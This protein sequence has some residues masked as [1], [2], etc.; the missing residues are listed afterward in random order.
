MPI[1]IACPHCRQSLTVP[2][3]AAGSFVACSVCR[4]SL[5]VPNAAAPVEM[6]DY[7]A[8]ISRESRDPPR[9]QPR[10]RQSVA[11]GPSVA[12]MTVAIV[13]GLLIV[14]GIIGGTF[15]G[16]KAYFYYSDQTQLDHHN[17]DWIEQIRTQGD[18]PVTKQY[19]QK[20]YDTLLKKDLILNR[21]TNWSEL[22]PNPSQEVRDAITQLEK[23]SGKSYQ[24]LYNPN[25]ERMTPEYYR[26]NYLND[27]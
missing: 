17:L 21:H 20:F 8:N 4:T 1:M 2:D 12:K 22:G 11:G 18:K 19:R 25:R 9:H 3:T 23:Q 6:E 14:A 16:R 26:N 15:Y 5:T 10:Y 27:E 7:L 24:D 13:L